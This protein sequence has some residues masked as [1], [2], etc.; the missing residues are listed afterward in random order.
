MQAEYSTYTAAEKSDE[1]FRVP[2]LIPDDAEKVHLVYN[3][4]K[5]GTVFA[6]ESAGGLTAGYCAPGR[7]TTPPANTANWLPHF[8]TPLD[9]TVCGD[10]SVVEENGVFYAWDLT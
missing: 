4:A 2:K 5:S 7:I 1:N 3:T 9:G 6:F 10:W 8:S